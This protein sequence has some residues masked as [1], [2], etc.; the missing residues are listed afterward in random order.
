MKKPKGG[1]RL[2]TIEELDRTIGLQLQVLVGLMK[3][4]NA[5]VIIEWEKKKRVRR[6]P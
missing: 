4:R 5:L 3:Q 6:Q 1:A 2:P